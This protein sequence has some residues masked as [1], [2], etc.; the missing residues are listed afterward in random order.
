MT[1]TVA[2]R[3]RRGVRAPRFALALPAIV[4]YALFFV[5]PIAYIVYYSFGT[6][7]TSLLLPV[8][9]TR[10]TTENYSQVFD[11]TFFTVFKGTLRISVIATALCVAI[12]LP[13][14]YF[15]TFKVS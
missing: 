8:D 2:G 10:L 11:A 6:K 7:D 12:G 3:T 5:V 13:V 15:A 1:G 14:A 4:W 9:L